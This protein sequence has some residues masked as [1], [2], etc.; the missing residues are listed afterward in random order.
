MVETS[1]TYPS[2]PLFPIAAIDYLYGNLCLHIPPMNDNEYTI[3]YII[4]V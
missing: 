4:L 1:L 2:F 3:C